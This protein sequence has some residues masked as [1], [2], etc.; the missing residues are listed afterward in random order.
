MQV[1]MQ[2]SIQREEGLLRQTQELAMVVDEQT[3]RLK[4]RDQELSCLE[5]SMH[6]G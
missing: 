4:E 3:L 1:E 2:S 6:F 5:S